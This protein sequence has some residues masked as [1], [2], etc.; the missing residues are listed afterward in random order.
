MMRI[1]VLRALIQVCGGADANARSYELPH[2][3]R[4]H[5]MALDGRCGWS[6][7]SFDSVN[8]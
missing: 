4:T 6:S 3:V 2:S 1:V 5:S 7:D 8:W